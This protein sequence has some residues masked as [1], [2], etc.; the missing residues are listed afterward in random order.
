MEIDTPV[1]D[2]EQIEPSAPEVTRKDIYTMMMMFEQTPVV[3]VNDDDF[4]DLTQEIFN[5]VDNHLNDIEMICDPK[6]NFEETMTSFELMDE[7]MDLRKQRTVV[8][9]NN[10]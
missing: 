9:V 8:A 6:F 1:V 4:E 2:Q 3:E 7:K 10:Q 5:A